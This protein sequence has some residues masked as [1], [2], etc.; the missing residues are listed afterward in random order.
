MMMSFQV[1]N[2][3]WAACLHGISQIGTAYWKFSD[4]SHLIFYLIEAAIDTDY[5]PIMLTN[6]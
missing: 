4:Q 5:F 1:P 2:M 3:R 6:V